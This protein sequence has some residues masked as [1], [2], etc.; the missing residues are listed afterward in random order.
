MRQS[1]IILLSLC[2]FAL[3]PSWARLDPETCGTHHER[4]KEELFLHRQAL[5]KQVRGAFERRNQPQDATAAAGDAG[6]I[7]LIEDSDG[8]VG[9]RNDFD[10]DQ[11]TLAFIPTQPQGAAY[12][13]EESPAG[14]DSA[15]ANAGTHFDLGDDDTKAAA[16]PFDFPFF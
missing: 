10:L 3:F 11:K 8:V 9:H 7:A 13:F 15:A 4:T 1:C 14:F 2:V 5:R 6:Q 12:R 16:L